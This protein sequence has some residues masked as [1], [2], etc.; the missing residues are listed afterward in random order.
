ML[1]LGMGKVN[2]INTLKELILE[3][4]TNETLNFT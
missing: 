1:S 4:I 3:K 2:P